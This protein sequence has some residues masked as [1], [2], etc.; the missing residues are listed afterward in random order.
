MAAV[1][2]TGLSVPLKE[3]FPFCVIS[4]SRWGV[5]GAVYFVVKHVWSNYQGRRTLSCNFTCSNF[6]PSLLM[7]YFGQ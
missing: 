7:D 5:V 3:L 4:V 1:E 6:L 2:G